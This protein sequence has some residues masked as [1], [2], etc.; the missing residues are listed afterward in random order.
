MNSES[1]TMS[2]DTQRV[3]VVT[4]ASRG[5]GKAIAERLAADGRHVVCVARSEGPLAE[6]VEKIRSAGGSAE[7]VT[8]DLSDG[9]SVGNMIDDVVERC[10]RIDVLV[11]NAG[12]TKDGLVMRMSDEDF[13][14]VLNVNLRSAFIA[15]RHVSR[16]M[17]R[18]RFG[19][20]INIGS[21]SGLMGNPG[22][23]NYA[24]SKAAMV[25]MSKSMAKELGSKGVTVNVVAPGFI[26]TD[27]TEML[28]DELMKE[29]A[30]RIP[31]RRL[32]EPEE[33]ANAV[34]WLSSD[35]SGYVTGQ[36]LVVDG[37]LAM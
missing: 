23:T 10:G 19:R 7:H 15:S 11:N 5:I 26:K 6:L 12:I 37:G 36:V 4:G 9:D 33:I 31:V 27:M 22:Q 28:G 25:G 20:I 34:S 29:V 16:P 8:C 3:A 14:D 30:P 2:D 17:M 35:E 18:A 24:A 32:G 1:S 13:D 21:V